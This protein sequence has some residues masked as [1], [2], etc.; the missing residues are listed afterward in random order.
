MTRIQQHTIKEFLT[1]SYF[2]Y[3]FY[4]FVLVGIYPLLL[5]SKYHINVYINTHIANYTLDPFFILYSQIFEG[6]AMIFVVIAFAFISKRKMACFALSAILAGILIYVLKDFVVGNVPRPTKLLPIESFHHLLEDRNVYKENYSF[7]SGHTT[8]A[9]AIMGIC[10]LITKS[11]WCSVLY[12]IIAIGCAFS[13]LYLLQ[14][15]FV[16]IYCGAI[17]G[18]CIALFTYSLCGTVLQ[19]KDEPLIRIKRN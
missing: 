10:A 1:K 17:I 13:R 19:I 15:F 5:Y 11:Q 7:P 12:F 16:D 14:H 4:A 8:F 9:F 3:L 2:A 18:F 6:W